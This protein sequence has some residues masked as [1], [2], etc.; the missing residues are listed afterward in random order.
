MDD[1]TSVPIVACLFVVYL[2]S[3]YKKIGSTFQHQESLRK[4]LAILPSMFH[5]SSVLPS[6]IFGYTNGIVI[7]DPLGTYK[8]STGMTR[9]RHWNS[10]DIFKKSLHGRQC[11]TPP[12]DNALSL[13]LASNHLLC[14]FSWKTEIFHGF[15]PPLSRKT[16]KN[17]KNRRTF[18]HHADCAFGKS[19]RVCSVWCWLDETPTIVFTSTNKL[20]SNIC[21]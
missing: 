20:Q 7:D 19:V 14:Q 12:S 2:P 17:L 21:I 9:Q 6:Y 8:W 4:Y 5:E 15:S 1:S 13:A 3:T 11:V 10:P 16:R 18:L